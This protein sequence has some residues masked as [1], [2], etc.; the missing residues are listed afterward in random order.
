MSTKNISGNYRTRAYPIVNIE[1]LYLTNQLEKELVAGSI[2]N[3]A[4]KFGYLYISGHQVSG[5]LI[6][7]ALLLAKSFFALSFQRKLKYYIGNSPNHRGYVPVCE[8]GDYDDEEIRR[9]EA[10]DLGVDLSPLSPNSYSNPLLGPNIWPNIPHFQTVI[11]RLFDA[12]IKLAYLLTSAVETCLGL[13]RDFLISKMSTPT[14]QLRLI[15]YLNDIDIK[16]LPSNEHDNS[17]GAHTD[18]ECFTILHQFSKGLQVLDA[19]DS[20]INV[21]PIPNALV[22]IIGDTL[23]AWTGGY[24]KS[25]VH[26]VRT[27][28][29][30]RYSMPF[31][32]ATNFDTIIEPVPGYNNSNSSYSPMIAGYHLMKMLSRDFPYLNKRYGSGGKNHYGT[33][34]EGNPFER[35]LRSCKEN[36]AA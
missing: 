7:D 8:K 16:F 30:E 22:V 5:T 26:R 33:Y 15:H 19:N 31:F 4:K 27:D 3:Y 1:S 9:Y 12:L 36:L 10:F 6:N 34:T 18:Y 29:Q 13:E 2:F 25:T 14:S 17:M 21:P 11:S 35:R 20:W 32:M 24:L 28:G 23:E